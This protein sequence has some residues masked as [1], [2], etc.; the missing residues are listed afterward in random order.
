M[1]GKYEDIKK[2]PLLGHIITKLTTY[3]LKCF[4]LSVRLI[5]KFLLLQVH[6]SRESFVKTL[7]CDVLLYDEI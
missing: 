4:S 7:E 1:F 5:K 3:R 6:S 2:F